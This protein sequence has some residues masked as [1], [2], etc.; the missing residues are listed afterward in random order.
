MP[1]KKSV[2]KKYVKKPTPERLKLLKKT[3]R[4]TRNNRIKQNKEEAN[5]KARINSLAE[6]AKLM[7][8]FNNNNSSR[9]AE[10]RKTEKKK[11]SGNN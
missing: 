9:K 7:Q 8:Q 4:K 2:K 6:F 10:T 5:A 1:K 11:K 3:L